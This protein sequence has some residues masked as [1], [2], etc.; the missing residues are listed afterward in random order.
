MNERKILASLKKIHDENTAEFDRLV[1]EYIKHGSEVFSALEPHPRQRTGRLTKKTK[2]ALNIVWAYVEFVYWRDQISIVDACK[3][4]EYYGGFPFEQYDTEDNRW[5]PA[6]EPKP[7][8]F[9]Y[10]VKTWQ[11]IKRAY[12]D[13]FGV[14]LGIGKLNLSMMQAAHNGEP[15]IYDKE[16]LTKYLPPGL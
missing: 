14:D 4:L 7:P 3:R 5:R 16:W 15:S 12:Y 11:D 13:S 9:S 8:T 1:R 2:D 6:D 10:H